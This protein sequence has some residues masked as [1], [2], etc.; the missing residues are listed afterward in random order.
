[1]FLEDGFGANKW[2]ERLRNAGF[3]VVCF[4]DDFK[5]DEDKPEKNV[6]DPRIINHCHRNKYV[7][8]TTDKNLCYTHIETVKKT[9]ILVIATESNSTQIGVWVEALIKGK[10]RIERLAH[11]SERPCSAR[12]SRDGKITV[13]TDYLKKTTTRKR[14]KEGQ[15]R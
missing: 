7:L 10:A 9:E 1:L 13:D 2:P 6:K 5:D 15:E 3:E 14:P 4:R 12:I 11:R 8:I